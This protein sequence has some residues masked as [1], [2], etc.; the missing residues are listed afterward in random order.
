MTNRSHIQDRI[1]SHILSEVLEGA[2]PSEITDTTPLMTGGILDSIAAMRL[3][4]FL[5]REFSISIESHEIDPEKFDTIERI[6]ELV[7]SKLT[8]QK[9]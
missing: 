4:V 2:E 6:A 3:V 8:L 7:E 1:R 5:E 9:L